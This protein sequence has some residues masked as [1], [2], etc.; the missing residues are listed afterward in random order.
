MT[1]PAGRLEKL[2]FVFH[3][4][5]TDDQQTLETFLLGIASQFL[6]HRLNLTTTVWDLPVELLASALRWLGMISVEIQPVLAHVDAD[7]KAVFGVN[8]IAYGGYIKHEKPPLLIREFASVY[9]ESEA[10]FSI[11]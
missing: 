2:I 4:W 9:R 10:S 5:F 6:E 8:F 1:E 11:L 7:D 3:G